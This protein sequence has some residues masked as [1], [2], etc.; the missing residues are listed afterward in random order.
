[1]LQLQRLRAPL[2]VTALC[3]R[4][5]EEGVNCFDCLSCLAPAWLSQVLNH[6]RG[7]GRG[8]GDVH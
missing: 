6:M 2:S 3:D 8:N 5:D 4:C 7:S 1:M